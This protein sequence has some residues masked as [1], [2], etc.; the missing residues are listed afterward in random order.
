MKMLNM[1]VLTSS[2]QR[3]ALIDKHLMFN[4]KNT[5]TQLCVAGV[6]MVMAQVMS[7]ALS[8][9]GVSSHR[10]ARVDARQLNSGWSVQLPHLLRLALRFHCLRQVLH[11]QAN[12]VMDLKLY[13]G[14]S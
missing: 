7:E 11:T 13:K 1:I 4:S 14:W 6:T 2:S 9:S 12:A 3:C 10:K 5:R 8:R